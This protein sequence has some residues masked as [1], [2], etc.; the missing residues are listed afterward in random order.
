MKRRIPDLLPI[1]RR[2]S[3]WIVRPLSGVLKVIDIVPEAG[4]PHRVLHIIPGYTAKRMLGD[5]SRDDDSEP[6][7]H[8]F[9]AAARTG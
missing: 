9:G 4:E 8:S 5:Q 6:W 7:T 2:A 1:P 3:L